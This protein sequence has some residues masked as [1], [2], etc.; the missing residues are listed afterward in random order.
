MRREYLDRQFFWSSVDPTR[1][2]E[3]FRDCYNEFPAHRSLDG[4]TPAQCTG[5]LQRASAALS[6]YAWRQ[7]CHGLLQT[8]MAA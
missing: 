7:H 5:K 6:F 3:A 2:L 8:P 4:T 1:K